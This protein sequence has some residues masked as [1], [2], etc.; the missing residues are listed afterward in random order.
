MQ[1]F[2]VSGLKFKSLV[3]F[4]VRYKICQF[5]QGLF[6]CLTSNATHPGTVAKVPPSMQPKSSILKTMPARARV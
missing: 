2:M 3:N 4:C 5:L 1:G 6:L